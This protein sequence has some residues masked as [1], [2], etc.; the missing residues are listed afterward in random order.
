MRRSHE[1]FRSLP[2][3][4]LHRHLEGS[5]RFD[6]L[7]ELAREVGLNIS[8]RE[9][10]RSTTMAGQRPGFRRFLSKFSIYRGL[11]PSREWVERVAYEAVEDARRDGIVYLELRFSPAHFARRMKARGEDV[12]DWV[13]GSARRAGVAVG[14]IATFGR[15]FTLEENEPTFRAVEGTDVFSGLD[16]AGDEAHSALPFLPFFKR[17]GLPVTIHAGETGR[18]ENVIEAVERFGARRIGHGLAVLRD[19]RAVDL[20]SRRRVVFETCLTSEIQTGAARSWARHPV[21]RMIDEGLLVTVNT[22]DPSVCGTSLG[23]EYSMAR[24]AGISLG[25]LRAAALAAADSS[26]LPVTERARL[27]RVIERGWPA[28]ST[29]AR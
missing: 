9:L 11:Y 17:A 13:A 24:R 19:P 15:D 2:K 5:V 14:F 10:R 27:R 21:R 22:D 25:D 18:P 7:R 3:I 1:V 26:F 23:M 6:T 12:A 28:E 29:V 20:A 8:A 4:D 16:V